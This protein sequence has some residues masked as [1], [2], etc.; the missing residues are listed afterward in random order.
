M[1]LRRF[2]AILLMS[3]ANTLILVHAVVPHYH[4]DGVVCFDAKDADCKSCEKHESSTSCCQNQGK[5]HTHLEDCDLPQYVERTGTSIEKDFSAAPVDFNFFACICILS[6]CDHLGYSQV[7]VSRYERYATY[8]NN[9]TSPYVG[10]LYGLR[11]PP[12]I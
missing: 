3:L 12:A 1:K 2:I 4:H 8:L 9:Y 11:A 6:D 10:A 5:H 7:V